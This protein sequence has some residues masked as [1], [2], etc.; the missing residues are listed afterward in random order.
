MGQAFGRLPMVGDIEN[1]YIL[2]PA[3]LR[4]RRFGSGSN[5][6]FVMEFDIAEDS[7]D[8]IDIGKIIKQ[9][10]FPDLPPLVFN[11]S[12][13]CAK[14]SWLTGRSYYADPRS[15]WFNV[16]FGFYEF[17]AP[18]S[19]WNRPFG[20]NQ[21]GTFNSNDILRITKA[22]WNLLSNHI[23]GVPFEKC[24]EACPITGDEIVTIVNENVTIGGYNY[25][26][27]IIENVTVITGYPARE[28]LELTYPLMTHV[29]R[30]I[31]G[32]TSYKSGYDEPFPVIRMKGH[33]YIRHE[34]SFDMDLNQNAYKTFVSGG[35]INMDY[36]NQQYIN[37]FLQAQ[38]DAVR[39][40]LER[41]PF[42]KRYHEEL[43]I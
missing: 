14:S 28:N 30:R 29:W 27:I 15:H 9:R 41:N 5:L 19:M 20:F 32:T 26:E 11:V 16:F 39:Y 23:Y 13:T 34:V 43:Y 8:L 31:F 37:D 38:L 4:D 40:S 12:F 25:M 17:D 42:R 10:I 3:R 2:K 6:Y 1:R 33:F 21:D 36:P 18:C 24:I 22:D 7:N 35:T